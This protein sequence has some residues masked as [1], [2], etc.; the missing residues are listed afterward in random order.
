[1]VAVRRGFLSRHQGSCGNSR[2]KC[3]LI[4]LPITA[5]MLT[6]LLIILTIAIPTT[7]IV[8]SVHTARTM[9]TVI[10]AL[11]LLLLS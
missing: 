8:T 1:M 5:C 11:I 10:S 7:S 3:I 2:L 4:I 9:T 6:T